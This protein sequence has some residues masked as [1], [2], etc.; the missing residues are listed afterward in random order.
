MNAGASF[1]QSY[2]PQNTTTVKAQEGV[3]VLLNKQ[4]GKPFT[5]EEYAQYQKYFGKDASKETSKSSGNT[6][7]NIYNYGPGQGMD[8][9]PMNYRPYNKISKADDALLRQLAANPS[10]NLK[11]YKNFNIGPFG[12]TKMTFGYKD[13][14]PEFK[15]T[16]NKEYIPTSTPESA[17]KFGPGSIDYGRSVSP[18]F[19]TTGVYAPGK[20]VEDML[21]SNLYRQKSSPEQGPANVEKGT[22]DWNIDINKRPLPS[23]DHKAYGGGLYEYQMAGQTP[24]SFPNWG[25]PIGGNAQT[26]TPQSAGFGQ[27]PIMM[28]GVTDQAA[29]ITSAKTTGFEGSIGPDKTATITQKRGANFNKEAAVNWGLAG[30]NAASSILEQNQDRS[31]EQLANS[32]IAGNAFLSKPANAMNQGDYNINSGDFREN[33]KV[34]VQFPGNNFA[35]N[36]TA[37][38]EYGGYME[39]GGAS[40]EEVYEDDLTDDEIAELRAQGYDVEYI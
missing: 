24:I 1:A 12:K 15:A 13:V 14:N 38:A 6:K 2:Q 8:H 29:P 30:M 31:S 39:N 18:E 36:R 21:I 23:I 35:T 4:T 19:N 22:N 3:Q 10:T 28:N 25:S 37:F 34:P 40:D 5:A 26:P 20:S 32:Q 33:Q 27:N 7:G 17:P 9:F 16:G 11:S